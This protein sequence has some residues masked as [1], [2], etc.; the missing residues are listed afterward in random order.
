[1]NTRSFTSRPKTRRAC[2]GHVH[3][4]IPTGRTIDKVSIARPPTGRACPP[5]GPGLDPP[6]CV[7]YNYVHMHTGRPISA[8]KFKPNILNT[9]MYQNSWT[10]E[11]SATRTVKSVFRRPKQT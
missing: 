4:L 8:A 7:Y 3:H 5:P 10:S 1:M 2:H 11:V 6:L 9:E